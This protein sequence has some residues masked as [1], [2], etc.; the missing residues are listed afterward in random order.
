MA[1][2]RLHESINR[3]DVNHT[4][5]TCSWT[6]LD[7]IIMNP[8]MSLE[9][10]LP[11]DDFDEVDF[12]VAED[13]NGMNAGIFM[14]RISKWSLRYMSDVIAYRDYHEDEELEWEEQE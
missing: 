8:E 1:L 3:D 12:I 14:L 7:T 13:W 5:K 4:D 10:F 9:T 11:P 2:V 6:D